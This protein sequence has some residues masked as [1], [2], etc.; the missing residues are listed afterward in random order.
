M[1][2]Y[3]WPNTRRS[4]V[5]KRGSSKVKRMQKKGVNQ[6]HDPI[7]VPEAA[8]QVGAAADAAERRA[9]LRAATDAGR[10]RSSAA[11]LGRRR[12]G[13]WSNT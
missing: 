8:P 7:S 13:T 9:G 5:H 10:A 12:C 2:C 3:H 4:S 6:E 11:R 1:I